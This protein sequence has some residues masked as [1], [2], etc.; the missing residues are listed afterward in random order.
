MRTVGPCENNSSYLWRPEKIA[1]NKNASCCEPLLAIS[2]AG[3]VNTC[4]LQDLEQWKI[5]S[6]VYPFLPK[7]TMNG[8][9]IRDF[10]AASHRALH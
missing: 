3:A 10:I 4:R 8:Q 1:A 2:R 5:V 9:F 7:L 6:N